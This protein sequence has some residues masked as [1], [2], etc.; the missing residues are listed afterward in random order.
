M[1][2]QDL[3]G[4]KFERLFVKEYS[5]RKG[6]HLY[7]LCICDC[8]KETTQCTTNLRRGN[9]VSCGC[10]KNEIAAAR[11]KEM[12]RI[13]YELGVASFNVLYK[14]YEHGAKGRDIPWNLNKEEFK[15]LTS[16]NCH[17]CNNS[18]KTT[19]SRRG[20]NGEYTY[21]GVDRLNSEGSYHMLNCVS[22]CKDC[23]L[24]KMDIPYRDFLGM[25][26]RVYNFRIKNEQTI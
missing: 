17:Y 26:E 4:L 14:Q 25:V 10:Y 23:N 19:I 22:C 9:V 21:N 16:G 2:R 6:K 20:V 5:H 13:K 3:Q 11:L 18:P 7:W 1:R 12:P 8:G 24:M 15:I